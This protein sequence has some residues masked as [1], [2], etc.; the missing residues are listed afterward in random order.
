MSATALART[1]S[2][3]PMQSPM[4]MARLLAHHDNY[5]LTLWGPADASVLAWIATLDRSHVYVDTYH[6]KWWM[7]VGVQVARWLGL[8]Y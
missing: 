2:H 4:Q 1:A 7:V 5:S 6:A 8:M 3:A